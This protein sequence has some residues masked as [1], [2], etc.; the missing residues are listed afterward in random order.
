MRQFGRKT[1]IAVSI[2]LVGVVGLVLLHNRGDAGPDGAIEST[3]A[4]LPQR[5]PI[6]PKTYL[7]AGLLPPTNKWFS[8]LAFSQQSPAVYAYPLSY[9]P[10]PTGFSISNPVL[11]SSPN[12]IFGGHRT[13]VVVNLHTSQHAVAAYDDL[14]VLVNQNNASGKTVAQSRITQGSPFVFTKINGASS[15]SITS[16]ANWKHVA[17]GEYIVTVGQ[18]TYGVYTTANAV[19]SGASLEL[20]A[21]K[22]ALLTVFAVP[23]VG[24]VESYFA[25]AGHPITG[26]DVHHTESD[27]KVITTLSLH[28]ESGSSLFAATPQMNIVGR[29]RAGS[30]TT[31][32]GSQPVYTGNDFIDSQPLPKLPELSLNLNKVSA[33]QRADLVAKLQ[34]DIGS[35]EF[36]ASDSYF[37]GKEL[38]RAANLLI[39]AKDLHQDKLARQVQVKLERQLDLWLDPHGGNERSTM[40]FYYDK[41]YHGVVGSTPSFGSDAFNDHHFHYGYF[42]YAAAAVARYDP[43]FIAKHG[44]MVNILI[45]DIASSSATTR[46]PKLR[47]FDAYAGHSWASGTGIFADGNNQESSSEAVN[48]WYATYLWSQVTHD[49]QLASQSRWL[50]THEAKAAKSL[51]LAA[52]KSVTNGSAYTHKTVGIVWGGKLD[53]STFFNPR[54]QAVLGIQLLPLSPGQAYLRDTT[55]QANIEDAVPT[56]SDLGGQF[57]D[58]IIMYEALVDPSKAIAD[59]HNISAKDLDSSNSLAYFYAWIYT[60]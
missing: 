42:V 34:T 16:S 6:V 44:A 15:L 19:M 24:L 30:F 40:Y 57:S 33:K 12:A 59:A 13:D 2:I 23:S 48:A 35:L 45:A 54:A 53:Y 43:S 38:Y 28:T 4:S 8:A 29:S 60:Q 17:Q 52:P 51:W 37:G 18:Q 27:G 21:K 32:L 25:A 7:T 58:A 11:L 26:T 55:V 31:L 9:Q 5:T 39:L 46:F 36:T 47:V 3:V 50:Y 22:D 56:P 1:F 20:T 41:L 10:T 49:K 14:S